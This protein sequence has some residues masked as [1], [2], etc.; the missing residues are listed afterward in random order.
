RLGA[1]AVGR[2]VEST[3]AALS[4]TASSGESQ[5]R[6]EAIATLAHFHGVPLIERFALWLL[7]ADPRVSRAAAVALVTMRPRPNVHIFDQALRSHDAYVQASGAWGAGALRGPS[8]MLLPLLR[9]DD[10]LVLEEALVALARMP[11]SVP[12]A[13]LLPL[14]HHADTAV[15]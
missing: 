11:G 13:Q 4:Q 10:S 7:D 1:D 6:V 15:C 5:H 9:S 12:A 14:L 3:V 8:S 2:P